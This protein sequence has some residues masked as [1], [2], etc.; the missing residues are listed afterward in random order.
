MKTAVTATKLAIAAFVV[1]YIFAMDPSMLFINTTPFEV[2]QICITAVVGIYAVSA[3]LSGY[4]KCMMKWPVRIIC[5]AS[6]LCLMIPGLATDLA[7]I[8]LM[9]VVYMIQT[10]AVKN[11]KTA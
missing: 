8:A 3:A 2:V 5:L 9:V 7:G 10:A 6:G 1:P 4:I 11:A